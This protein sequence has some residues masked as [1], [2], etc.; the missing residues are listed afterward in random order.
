[1]PIFKEH[2][3]SILKM[4]KCAWW[5]H[6]PTSPGEGTAD[7][8]ALPRPA[9][10]LQ[11]VTEENPSGFPWQQSTDTSREPLRTG[12][13]MWRG[14]ELDERS[15]RRSRNLGCSSESR[16]EAKLWV[17]CRAHH[18]AGTIGST[19]SFPRLAFLTAT[20]LHEAEESLG[21]ALYNKRGRQYAH[22]NQLVCWGEWPLCWRARWG[23]EQAGSMQRKL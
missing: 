11:P 5:G 13:S 17:C 12:P 16:L 20:I 18:G 1:M 14:A 15:R 23:P 7:Y 10:Q 22:A 6:L 21:F 3:C 2:Y 4:G 19:G 8:G 9:R